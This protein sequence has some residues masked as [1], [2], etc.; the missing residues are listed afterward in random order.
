MRLMLWHKYGM[1][2]DQ[3]EVTRYDD[4]SNMGSE[5]GMKIV[6]HDVK[7]QKAFAKTVSL[8]TKIYSDN[9]FLEEEKL[10]RLL[11]E[12][13]RRR[14]LDPDG[15][16]IRY[17]GDVK[18]TADGLLSMWRICNMEEQ[19]QNIARVFDIYRQIP[20]FFF[21]CERGSINTS[22][23]KVFGDRID[24]TL[25][26]LKKY[27]TDTKDKCY[28]LNAYNREKTNK[29]LTEMK[30]FENLI[31]WWGV[32]GTFTDDEYNIFD[33]EYSDNRI[34]ETYKTMKEY[35]LPWNIGYYNNVKE[36]INLYIK[37][38]RKEVNV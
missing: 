25:F 7:Y 37:T 17:V 19:V 27:Y 14:K 30:S 3:Y 32:K 23:A 5:H 2:T 12:E 34:I 4:E 21:P 8:I 28:L 6:C 36:R 18:C 20:I 24:H 9:E 13:Y 1:N 11:F 10:R 29:W 22:R 16:A 35:Q 31:D 33:L 15:K 38:N 26:D